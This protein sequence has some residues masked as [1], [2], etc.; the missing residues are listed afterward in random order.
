MSSART[1]PSSLSIHD[2]TL[3]VHLLGLV[4]FDATL[5]LQEQ[6]IYEISGRDDRNG[7]LFLCEHPTLISMGRE[8]SRSQLLLDDD[9]LARLGL[10]V[11]WVARGGGAY[12]HAPG[13]L[14]IYLQLPLQRLGVSVIH[15][16]ALFESSLLKLCQEL[17]IPAKLQPDL[18][19]IWSRN[20]QLGFFG[21][22]VKSWV[23][24]HGMF[25]NISVDPRMLEW[26]LS[27]PAGVRSTTMQSQRL[28]PVRMPQVREGL[29]RHIADAFGY[30]AAEVSTGHP[31]LRRTS[32][33][34]LTHA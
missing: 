34:V 21:A 3:E 13:Q 27:N 29:I 10:P 14:A 4:D 5:G 24:C 9:E 28:D 30:A 33:R 12:L 23:S 8:A 1:S 18:A 26:T 16:R 7:S 17:K 32:Q 2:G 31:L 6:Q 19:G 25:L 15:Y 11:R 22:A 20:G